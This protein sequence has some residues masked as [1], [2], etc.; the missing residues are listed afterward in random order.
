MQGRAVGALKKLRVQENRILIKEGVA[1][2][3]H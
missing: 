2:P 3:L 1:S